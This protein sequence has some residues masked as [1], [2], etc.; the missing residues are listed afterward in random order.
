MIEEESDSN[1]NLVGR[2]RTGILRH[3]DMPTVN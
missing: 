2:M 1:A 3:A